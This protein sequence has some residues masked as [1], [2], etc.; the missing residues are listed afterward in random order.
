MVHETLNDLLVE[1]LKDIYDAEQQIM[2]ALPKMAEA[3]T[4]TELK[5]AFQMHLRQT[6]GHIARLESAFSILSK[7]A[8]RKPCKAM[9]GLIAEGEDLMKE[10]EPSSLLDAGLIGAAQ[11][12]EHYEMAAYGTSR[13][14]AEALGQTDIASLLQQTLD[15]EK[16]TDA[17]LNEL[18]EQ[19]N[20]Q[21]A[22]AAEGSGTTQVG[23]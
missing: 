15:E 4:S 6:E 14:Y 1:E 19:I 10:H 8:E 11:R 16:E 5:S 21:C 12:V 7:A 9:K 20:R 13:A 18:G 23:G 3:A 17:S 2:Q 22:Q